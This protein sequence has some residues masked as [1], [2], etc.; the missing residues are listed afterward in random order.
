MRTIPGRPSGT[1]A[2]FVEAGGQNRIIVVKG[3]NDRLLPADVDEAHAVLEA[4]D[5]IV[6]QFEIPRVV[7]GDTPP[8]PAPKPR[9]HPA[10]R[11]RPMD[12]SQRRPFHRAAKPA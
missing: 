9:S 8:A 10:S 3:A 2:I 12:V 5:C 1:A 7:V 4:A 6:L 11:Y